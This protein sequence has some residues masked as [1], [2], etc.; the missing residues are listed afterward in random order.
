[1]PALKGSGG[2]KNGYR[3]AEGMRLMI[4]KR[5]KITRELS[6]SDAW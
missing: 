6:R 4:R 5:V 3:Q 2:L 1:M